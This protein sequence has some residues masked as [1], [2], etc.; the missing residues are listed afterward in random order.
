[1]KDITI[2]SRLGSYDITAVLGKGGMGEVYRA[3][4]SKLKRDVAIKI[5]PREF[6]GDPDR[7]RRLVS[8]RVADVFSPNWTRNREILAASFPVRA[9]IWHFHH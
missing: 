3:R 9:S 4:D 2:G 5:L 7:V 1:M 8:H 6:S